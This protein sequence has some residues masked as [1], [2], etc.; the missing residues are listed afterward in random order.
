MPPP[1]PSF[2]IVVSEKG[3]SERR[4]SFTADVVNIGRVQG[5]DLALNKS[6]VSKQHASLSYRDG[7]FT[8]VD[9]G[10]TNGTYINRR[11]IQGPTKVSEGDRLY[12][13][14]FVLRMEL[15]EHPVT[16][17]VES[18]VPVE[19]V[20]VSSSSSSISDSTT[21][22]GRVP[23]EISLA[24]AREL[25]GRGSYPEVP[26]APK[27]P[28]AGSTVGSWSDN[29]TG[30][31][32]L[33]TEDLQ[34]VARASA[35][36]PAIPGLAAATM[37]PAERD[38]LS[39][40]LVHLVEGVIESLGERWTHGHTDSEQHGLVE[41]LLEEQ[42]QRLSQ[43][44]G[45]GHNIQSDK[46]RAVART[47]ILGLGALGRLFE[48]PQITEIF[49]LRHDQIWVR[50]GA[51]LE[52]VDG[53]LSSRRSLRRII[54]RLCLKAGKPANADETTIERVLPTGGVVCAVLPPHTLGQPSLI[55]RKPRETP[56][57]LQSLVRVGVVSRVMSVFLQQAVAGRARILVVGSRDAEIAAVT[58]ALLSSVTEGPLAVVEGTMDLGVVSTQVPCFR[59]SMVSVA[60]PR[61][62][63]RA[64]S[65]VS[66]TQFGVVL[67]NASVTNALVDELGGAGVG[68]VAAREARSAILALEQLAMELV[69]CHAG[70][71]LEAARR[72]I[73]GLFDVVL[74]VVRF[75]DGRQRVIR[76]AELRK[77]TAEAIEIED[78]FTFVAS[79]GAA[80]DMV[81]GTFRSSGTVPSFVEEMLARGFS[82]DTNVFN[83]PASR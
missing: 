17:A 24:A 48:D 30:R 39:A 14:D 68:F 62:L 16:G 52:S 31:H 73:A 70:M 6:N 49:V 29:S 2:V 20:D 25:G 34:M 82:F 54:W 83:R 80:S 36:E 59:W 67:E 22:K 9:L 61:P 27:L 35:S 75:R 74:E 41:K 58:G 51:S 57:S 60:D 8:I 3:G 81:E 15:V 78:V 66:S 1:K 33:S 7:L 23:G 71:S 63:I 38:V 18:D 19:V 5:N 44:G 45:L 13:G 32:T 12:V 46:L 69:A 37:A 26:A 55:Y 47:E 4:E 53:G 11:R 50:R 77:A 43:G 56:S 76:I 79:S 72:T 64:A 40:A 28:T 10:S 21:S 65:R 42:W